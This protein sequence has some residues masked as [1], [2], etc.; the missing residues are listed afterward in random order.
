MPAFYEGKYCSHYLQIQTNP[1]DFSRLALFFFPSS[2]L[3]CL[4][5]PCIFSFPFGWVPNLQIVLQH[6][7]LGF[8]SCRCSSPCSLSQVDLRYYWSHFCPSK[9]FLWSSIYICFPL[10]FTS[11]YIF[12]FIVISPPHT[13]RLCVPSSLPPSHSSTPL[14]FFYSISSVLSQCQSVALDAFTIQRAA[15][16]LSTA[17]AENWSIWFLYQLL[18]SLHVLRYRN[19]R[20]Y[21]SCYKYGQNLNSVGR[22]KVRFVLPFTPSLVWGQA[23]LGR[24]K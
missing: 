15:W 7:R 18:L 12:H 19:V 13:A 21:I 5:P 8:L 9:L 24:C 14:L 23:R 6:D 4:T 22:V 10:D 2:P 20:T 1:V 11:L 16:R 3:L 17:P